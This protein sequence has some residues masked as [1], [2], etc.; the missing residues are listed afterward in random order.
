MSIPEARRVSCTAL[1]FA[2]MHG[3]PVQMHYTKPQTSKFTGV[4]RD[5]LDEAIAAGELHSIKFEG[6]LGA[7]DG[8]CDWLDTLAPWLQG[9]IGGACFYAL[10][11]LG[12][13]V[14]VM[15]Q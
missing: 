9:L 13:A 12:C 1:D 7:V 5:R 15:Y 3:F 2:V 10:L 11:W 4:G 14:A 8:V 6:L